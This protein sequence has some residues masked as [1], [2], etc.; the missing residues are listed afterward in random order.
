MSLDRATVL[1]RPPCTLVSK[2]SRKVN[3]KHSMVSSIFDE[4][5]DYEAFATIMRPISWGPTRRAL[6]GVESSSAGG[7]VPFG[8][9][10]KM[11]MLMNQRKR[12][13]THLKHP[14]LTG[15]D[16]FDRRSLSSSQPRKAGRLKRLKRASSSGNRVPVQNAPLPDL[17]PSR[18]SV[19]SPTSALQNNRDLIMRCPIWTLIIYWKSIVHG[20]LLGVACIPCHIVLYWTRFTHAH[21]GST[22]DQSIG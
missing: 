8:S 15:S 10:S 1:S 18:T 14:H 12:R 5:E 20:V 17:T 13:A 9:V 19:P 4:N 2:C 7:V 21:T 22:C 16:Y 6:H 11:S 3:L